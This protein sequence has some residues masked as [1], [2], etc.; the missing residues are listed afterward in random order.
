MGDVGDVYTLAFG[1]PSSVQLG[2]LGLGLKLIELVLVRS[3]DL[4]SVIYGSSVSILRMLPVA[5]P[6]I[7]P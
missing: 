1:R 3:R 6:E 7:K 4:D 5:F 2:S